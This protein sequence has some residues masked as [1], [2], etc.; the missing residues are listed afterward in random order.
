MIPQRIV[1]GAILV[2][3]I[4]FITYSAESTREAEE[5]KKEEEDE[6]YVHIYHIQWRV[7]RYPERGKATSECDCIC[8]IEN[9]NTWKCALCYASSHYDTFSRRLRLD[10]HLVPRG[11]VLYR[12]SEGT[13]WYH[14]KKLTSA[15][16][17]PSTE[18]G[19]PVR[20]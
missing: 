11:I 12:S 13:F 7:R 17:L 20:A 4:D 10:A 15:F 5:E 6:A 9:T 19:V 3:L 8:Q 2:V 1:C 16:R 18:S 14:Q